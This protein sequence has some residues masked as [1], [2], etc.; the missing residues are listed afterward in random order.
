MKNYSHRLVISALFFFLS[1]LS[2][3][4]AE[5]LK[6]HAAGSLKAA[7]S[8]VA[9]SFEIPINES[10]H[11]IRPQRSSDNSHCR[12][13]DGRCVCICE[14]GTPGKTRSQWMGRSCGAVCP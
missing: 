7:L 2:A 8:E 9:V 11:K 1:S 3:S 14:Y 4:A 6:L 12:W 13:R 5:P 10:C